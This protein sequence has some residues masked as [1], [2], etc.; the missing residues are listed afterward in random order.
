MRPIVGPMRGRSISSILKASAFCAAV[1]GCAS[2][3]LDLSERQTGEILTDLSARVDRERAEAKKKSDAKPAPKP[4]PQVEVPPVLSLT[5]ALRIAGAKNRDLMTSR[6]GLTLAA[7]SLLDAQNAV[8]PRLAGSVSSIL[9]GDDRAEKVRTNAGTLSA[10]TLLGTGATASVTGDAQHTHGLGDTSDTRAGSAVVGRISQPLL[11]GAGYESSHE[12]LT[13]AERQSLYDVR[14]FE[15]SRQDLAL[16]VQRQFYGLVTQKQVIRNRE[17]SLSNFDF[18]KRRSDRLFELGRVSEV[19]KF[20]AAREYL[21]AEN[22]L[23]D[24]KQAYEFQIDRFKLTLGV[25]ATTKLDVAE[26]IPEPRPAGIELR[27]AID[28]ALLNRLDLMTARDTVDDAERRVRIAERNLLPDLS[29]EA[30]GRSA[31]LDDSR[32][33]DSA[34]A[35]D[36]YSLGLSLVLPLDRVRERGALRATHI[37]LNRARRN[38]ATTEDNVILDVRQALRSLRSAEASLEIQVQ[39]A[40]SEEK[41]VKVARMRFER[42][43]ISNRDLTDAMTNL[44]DARDRLVREQAT[45]ETARIQLLRNLGVLYLDAEGIWHE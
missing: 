4:E 23:V 40:A 17:L 37:E 43:E 2:A 3:Q 34:L 19:D 39:I 12:F 42:G 8:G 29:V 5:D 45:A 33:V 25:D 10:T 28:V 44:V 35:R 15:L 30:V 27:R 31:S 16:E 22:D 6:E 14:D 1:A 11:R 7:L 36:S 20:R 13:T 32:H 41:N 38:L 21:V 24:A 18:V 26:E 9:T